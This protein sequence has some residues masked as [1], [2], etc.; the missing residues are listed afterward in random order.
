MLYNN[1][2]Y[3][4]SVS[5]TSI[6]IFYLTVNKVL[7]LNFPDLGIVGDYVINNLSWQIGGQNTMSLSLN[8]AVVIV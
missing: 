3:N 8:E 6:P 2:V 4:A 7:R 1:L 5:L